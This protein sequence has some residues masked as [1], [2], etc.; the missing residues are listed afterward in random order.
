MADE[1]MNVQFNQS[2][3]ELDSIKKNCGKFSAPTCICRFKT[4]SYLT[5]V[6]PPHRIIPFLDRE[7]HAEEYPSHLMLKISA[8]SSLGSGR[9][10]PFLAPKHSV[11][12]FREFLESF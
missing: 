6:D 8:Q 11:H 5:I 10:P 7:S 12:C 9:A 1:L 2:L 4:S 3:E